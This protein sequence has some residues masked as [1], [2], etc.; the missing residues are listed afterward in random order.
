MGSEPTRRALRRYI[1]CT[2]QSV[3]STVGNAVFNCRLLAGC[4]RS[5]AAASWMRNTK[6]PVLIV[7]Q[8]WRNLTGGLGS[9]CDRRP[10]EFTA[11]DQPLE[12]GRLEAARRHREQ[13]TLS[14][15][16][17][18]RPDRPRYSDGCPSLTAAKPAGL[19]NCRS[20]PEATISRHSTTPCSRKRG[21]Q[22]EVVFFAVRVPSLRWRRWH[23]CGPCALGQRPSVPL[24]CNSIA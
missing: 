6:K 18:R 5:R 8:L 20:S 3:T 10:A 1:R 19:A 2:L 14:R 4:R 15:P 12:V 7:G 23:K 22:I 11:A 24:A 21:P 13:P 17:R 16:S 9:G